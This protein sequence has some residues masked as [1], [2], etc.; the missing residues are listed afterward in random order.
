MSIELKRYRC[1]ACGVVYVCDLLPGET[2]FCAVCGYQRPEVIGDGGQ[3]CE[4]CGCWMP[5][6]RAYG[7]KECGL[8]LCSDCYDRSERCGSCEAASPLKAMQAAGTVQ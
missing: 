2:Y 8:T 5:S 4:T 7:C 6:D 1:A 3:R